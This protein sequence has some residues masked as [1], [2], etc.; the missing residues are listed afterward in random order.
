MRYASV[1]V[2]WLGCVACGGTPAELAELGAEQSALCSRDFDVSYE[3]CSEFAGI[4]YVPTANAR[5]LVPA[6]FTLAGDATNAVIVVRVADCSNAIVGGQALGP[7]RTAQIGLSLVGPDQTAY[8]NNYTLAFS[9]NQPLLRA[10]FTAAGVSADV[11][12]QLDYLL[13]DSGEL[14]IT[15]KSPH[16]PTFAVTGR[17]TPPES[18]PVEFIA[19][20]WAKGPNGVIQ[21][22]TV[23]PDIQFGAASTTLTSPKQTSLAALIGGT[24]LVFPALDS[25]NVFPS[26]ALAV[27]DTD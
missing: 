12:K 21:A 22:R 11:A 16:T 24:S 17:A 5:P 13:S 27:R 14:S 19:S 26:A 8:I 25:Y 7:T 3:E 18:D 15:S 9:T 23:L 20:W 10:K 1:G 2:A 4:G 6:E